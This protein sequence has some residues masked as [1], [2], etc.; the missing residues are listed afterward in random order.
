MGRPSTA[1]CPRCGSKVTWD[2][3][4]P[5]RPFCSERCHLI[6]LGAWLSEE[7]SIPGEDAIVPAQQD[8]ENLREN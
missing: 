5:Y 1:R 3:N 7:H 2:E 4:S 8:A 6:D